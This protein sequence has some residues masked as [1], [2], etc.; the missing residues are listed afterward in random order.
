MRNLIANGRVDVCIIQ[1]TKMLSMR[2]FIM[3]S[4]WGNKEVVGLRNGLKVERMVSLSCRKLIFSV[5]FFK[6]RLCGD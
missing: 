3:F 1:E 2:N 5:L 4:L 6:R